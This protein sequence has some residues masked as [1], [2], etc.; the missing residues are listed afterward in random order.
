MVKNS[1]IELHS[2][3]RRLLSILQLLVFP[4]LRIDRSVGCVK[5]IRNDDFVLVYMPDEEQ[6]GDGSFGVPVSRWKVLEPLEFPE[7]V[8]GELLH[9]LGREHAMARELMKLELCLLVSADP[10]PRGGFINV[11]EVPLHEHVHERHEIRVVKGCRSLC[12]KP[13]NSLK[14]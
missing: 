10:E 9:V 7:Y 14:V 6:E 8:C 3:L 2:Q 12:N 1:E 5:L 4:W 13:K 11:G